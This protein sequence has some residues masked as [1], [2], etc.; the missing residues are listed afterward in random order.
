MI[1]EKDNRYYMSDG[2]GIFYGTE[3]PKSINKAPHT[4]EFVEIV[5]M[6]KGKCTHIIDGKE[7]FVR[8]GDMVI[9][10]YNQT[11]EIKGDSAAS[12]INILIK[13]KYI[14]QSLKNQ[15]NAF[16]LLNLSEFNDFSKILDMSK[17][18][19]TF[20]GDERDQAENVISIISREMAEKAPGY[21]LAIHSQFNLLLIMIF[22]KMSLKLDGVVWGINDELLA[23]I[24]SH[25]HENFSLED[26]AKMCSYNTSYFS[27]KFKEFAGVT[28]RT[29]L[30]NARLNKAIML[31]E[32]TDTKVS[33]IIEQVGYSDRTK[34]FSHFAAFTG[35]TPLKYRNSKK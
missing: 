28:F 32:T 7:Y 24:K 12:Y 35:M 11:H 9:I 19:I 22:R 13:P 23:Y 10:N 20:S 33:D 14:N 25:C 4:H 8:H 1:T 26:M 30:K 2:A 21:E 3:T 5:Y 18:K 27:R 17:C 29:Y 16:A 6:L 15:E 34:F 31:L